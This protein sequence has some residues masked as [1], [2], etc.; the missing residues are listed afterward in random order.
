LG[1]FVDLASSYLGWTFERK[2]FSGP[3]FGWHLTGVLLSSQTVAANIGVQSSEAIELQQERKKNLN[4]K[5]KVALIAR[6]TVAVKSCTLRGAGVGLFIGEV[7][8]L[9]IMP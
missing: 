1:Y 2:L 5:R 7:K 6:Q 9:I 3:L 4:E 8:S